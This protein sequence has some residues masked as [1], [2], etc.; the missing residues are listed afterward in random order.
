MYA[1]GAGGRFVRVAGHGVGAGDERRLHARER[2]GY[3]GAG[4]AGVGEPRRERLRI[5]NAL[6]GGEPLHGR[7]E[8]RGDRGVGQVDERHPAHRVGVL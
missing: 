6:D 5:A 4:R 2:H 7:D 3:R 1:L 8:R